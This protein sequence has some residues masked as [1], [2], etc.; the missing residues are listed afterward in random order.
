MTKSSENHPTAG[1][2]HP[3]RLVDQPEANHPIFIRAVKGIVRQHEET[4]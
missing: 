2:N 3:I 4:G 1:R